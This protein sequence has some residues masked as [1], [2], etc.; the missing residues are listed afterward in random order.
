[1]PVSSPPRR[2]RLRLATSS[3]I[4]PAK[5]FYLQRMREADPATRAFLPIPSLLEIASA[6]AD[7]N[8]FVLTDAQG[9]IVAVS[10]LF[11]LLVHDHGLFMELSGMCTAGEVGGLTPRSVQS[12]M[13]MARIL[14][15]AYDLLGSSDGLSLASFVHR[16]NERSRE[17]L[18]AAGLEEWSERPDWVSG[19]YVSWFGWEGGDDWLTLLVHPGCVVAAFDESLTLGFLAGEIPLERVSRATGETEHFLIE[20][21]PTLFEG[22]FAAFFETDLGAMAI[23]EPPR[24]LS[25]TNRD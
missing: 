5:D 25:F 9:S 18:N 21:D 10:G 7:R 20:V 8:F 16:D 17:N 11:R 24:A 19:E 15:A 1:M 13:L 3:D 12:I 23:G 6:V 2:H 22:Q 14:H 4:L